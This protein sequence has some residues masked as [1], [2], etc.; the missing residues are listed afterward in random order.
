[1]TRTGQYKGGSIISF[2]IVTIAIAALLIGGI[3]WLRHRGDVARQQQANE[4]AVQQ[5]EKANESP[6]ANTSETPVPTNQTS[7][8]KQSQE[9]GATDVTSTSRNSS[10]AKNNSGDTAATPTTLPET[11][12][13][14]VGMAMVVIGILS[15]TTA[16]YAV[17][18]RELSRVAA[19]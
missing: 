1:M 2:I 18:K 12:P 10:Q 5:G 3:M 19:L 7:D 11:G 8:K 4:V 6:A 13:I 14:E 15:Y 9:S 16:R 17:S